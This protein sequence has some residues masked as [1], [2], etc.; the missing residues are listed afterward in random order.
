VVD[1]YKLA[2]E[3]DPSVFVDVNYD[4]CKSCVEKEVFSVTETPPQKRRPGRPATG[5][6]PAVSARLRPEVLA[7]VEIWAAAKGVSVSQ[8]VARLIEHGLAAQS[9]AAKP[10]RTTPPKAKPVRK[11]APPKRRT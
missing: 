8:A 5:T 3:I 7:K 1:Q 4:K 10:A 6:N 9:A 11:T 2:L